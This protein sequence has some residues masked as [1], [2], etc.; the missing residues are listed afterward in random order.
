MWLLLCDLVTLVVLVV[1][2]SFIQ[3]FSYY[4]KMSLIPLD[5]FH[6]GSKFRSVCALEMS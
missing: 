4:F 2:F 3:S 5:R 6:L 1:G